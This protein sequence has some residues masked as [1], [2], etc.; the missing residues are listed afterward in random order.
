MTMVLS[1]ELSEE[2][3]RNGN[4]PLAVKDPRTHR[5]YVIMPADDSSESE[6]VLDQEGS[7]WTEAK[8]ARRFALIDKDVTGTISPTEAIEL[9]RLQ[10]EVDHFLAR[11]APLPIAEAR[12]LHEE[13]MKLARERNSHS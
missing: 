7:D 3:A 4:R 2:L 1:N 11:V 6:T 10:E 5:M 13:L 9:A 8:N 12:Q